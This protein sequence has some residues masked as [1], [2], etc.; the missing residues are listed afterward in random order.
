MAP[1]K[2]CGETKTAQA[3]SPSFVAAEGRALRLFLAE[4]SRDNQML[5]C[6]FLK[7]LHCTI[8]IA[9][10][11]AIA[12]D[13]FKAR[14]YDLVLMDVQ[15]PVMDGLRA[16]KWIREWE[17][18]SGLIHTPII[19][20]TA[21]AL[22]DNTRDALAAGANLHI[23]KPVTRRP[24]WR[25]YEASRCRVRPRPTRHKCRFPSPSRSRLHTRDQRQSEA[26]HPGRQVPSISAS[27]L[28]PRP[29]QRR[30]RASIEP[31]RPSAPPVGQRT[32]IRL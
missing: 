5:V 27:S 10:D 28:A 3:P 4:D 15:M 26:T 6:A 16:M 17:T 25:E 20:L 9:D 8:D 31:S 29:R 19:A 7:Q 21:S 18:R 14:K 11:G 12:I 32:T 30:V 24:C 13:K 23:S 2:D 22:E 1:P